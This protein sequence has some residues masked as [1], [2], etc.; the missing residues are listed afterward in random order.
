MATSTS[1]RRAVRGGICAAIVAVSTLTGHAG[2]NRDSNKGNNDKQQARLPKLDPAAVVP[3][4]YNSESGV[5]R[6]ARG[7]VD[8]NANEFFIDLNSRGPQG[9][10]GATGPSGATGP[11]GPAGPIGPG[12]PT[13]KTGVAGPQG[14]VGPAGATGLTGATGPQGPLGPAGP[15]GANGA[16]G[17]EGLVGPAGPTGV[18]G[19]NG[20]RG[21]AG[22]KGQ[23]GPQGVAGD[24][25]QTGSQGVAGDKGDKGDKG[26]TGPQGLTGPTGARDLIGATGAT[27]LQGSTGDKGDVGAQGPFG[28]TGPA[29]PG[30]TF[31]GLWDIDTGYLPNDVVTESGSSFIAVTAN[32]AADPVVASQSVGGAWATLASSGAVGPAGPQGEHGATGAQGLVGPIGL[33]GDA[34]AQGAQ[35]AQGPQGQAGSA[36]AT[37]ASGTTGQGALSVV[38]TASVALTATGSLT[39]IPGLSI[40]A[41]VT[42]ATS[43]VLVSSDGGVQVS[44]S[45]SGQAVVVDIYLFVDGD[46]T[47]KQIVQRR[48]Y[49]VNSVIV[50]NITNWSFSVAVAGLAPGMTHTFRVSAALV[51]ATTAA[52]PGNWAVVASGMPNPLR[53]TLTAVVINR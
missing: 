40:G 24:K 12:G 27:G 17:P 20:P 26:D 21:V 34:G 35:G 9:V 50:P 18:T 16:T 48:L 3:S 31:R 51:V 8:C 4:C 6:V 38:S 29:G 46:T 47:P 36:G 10:M 1:L 41:N 37:G 45:L 13:G 44:S 43:A 23:T 33:K 22:D 52:A 32:L 15:T 7:S 19:A 5:W 14:L 39:D 28:A 49:A 53:G 42:T 30:L 2:Q 11:Q 25:G